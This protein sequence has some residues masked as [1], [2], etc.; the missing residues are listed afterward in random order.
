MHSLISSTNQL[1][2][3]IQGKDTTIEEATQ[4]SNLALK[5]L[6]IITISSLQL[7]GVVLIYYKRKWRLSAARFVP[8]PFLQSREENWSA[9]PGERSF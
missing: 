1:S 7:L 8:S 6:E 5:L 4:A 9:A 2:I 3:T